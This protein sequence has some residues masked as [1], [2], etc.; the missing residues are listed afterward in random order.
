[1]GIPLGLRFLIH[2]SPKRQNSHR[3]QIDV[4]IACFPLSPV[5]GQPQ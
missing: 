1:M 3:Q 5:E 2:T 4:S